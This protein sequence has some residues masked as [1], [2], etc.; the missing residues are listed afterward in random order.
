MSSDITF[1]ASG[2]SGRNFLNPFYADSKHPAMS[3]LTAE[4][5]VIG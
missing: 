5:A 2:A 1:R 3:I 4:A